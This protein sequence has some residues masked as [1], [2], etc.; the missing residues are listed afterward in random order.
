MKYFILAAL[1]FSIAPATAQ[2]E[3][4]LDAISTY[5]SEYVDDQRF[6][7]VY[8]SGKMFELFEDAEID[9]AE[10]DEDEVRAIMEVVRE[11]KGI[12]VLSTD[13]T[14]RDFYT[15]AKRRIST[16]DYELLFKVRTKGGQNVEAFVQNE[17]ALINELF[18]LVGTDDN[19][20]LLSFVGNIDLTKISELRSALK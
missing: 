18:M 2:T 13:E 17:E 20:T 14:P 7:A 16:D 19:F 12:R 4:R 3:A 9:L 10:M 8:V 11:V 15:E 5:F 6:T 1:L